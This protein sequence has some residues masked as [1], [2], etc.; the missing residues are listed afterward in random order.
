MSV[1]QSNA[2]KDVGIEM[3]KKMLL[4]TFAGTI[5]LGCIPTRDYL[6]GGGTQAICNLDIAFFNITNQLAL[7]GYRYKAQ[8]TNNILVVN[9]SKRAVHGFIAIDQN[10]YRPNLTGDLIDS[11]VNYRV[12]TITSWLAPNDAEASV[13]KIIDRAFELSRGDL[14]EISRRRK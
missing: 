7:A 1:K 5:L 4:S 8:T 11:G 14:Y 10:T 6:S 2:W 12:E 13:R 3:T 9:F